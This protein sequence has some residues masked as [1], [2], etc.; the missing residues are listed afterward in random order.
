MKK[1]ISALTVLTAITS[2]AHPGHSLAESTPSHILTSPYHLGVL[3]LAG[4]AM[5]WIGLAVTQ[6]RVRMALQWVGAFAVVAAAYMWR[7]TA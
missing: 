1:L 3:A 7:M 2:Q 6:P 4:V 5:C